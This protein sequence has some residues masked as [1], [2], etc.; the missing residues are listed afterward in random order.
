MFKNIKFDKHLDQAIEQLQKG[1]FLTTKVKNKVNTMTISWGSIGVIW[2]KPMFIVYVR[3]T[4]DT[5]QMLEEANEFTI[6]IPIKRGLKD[7]LIFC[8]TK[9]GRDYDKIKECGFTLVKGITVDTPIISECDLHYECKIVYKQAMESGIIP[10]DVKT[11]FYSKN[12]YHMIYYG[13]I[14]NT[15]IKKE[16]NDE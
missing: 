12:N 1:V 16:K 15:Y 4:R 7:E 2:N 9:S 13:E 11:R 14:T 10:E 6:S 8:G 3:Y 5:Y